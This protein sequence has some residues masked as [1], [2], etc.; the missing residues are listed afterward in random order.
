MEI[1]VALFEDNKNL[2][3]SLE[4]LINSSETMVCTGAFANAT[5]LFHD[6]QQAS[7]D[8]VMMDINM[9]GLSGIEAVKMI[10]EKFPNINILKAN[11]A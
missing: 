1:K 6:L 10:K 9:P 11:C 3:E 5:K 2:R 7:P 8:V 4:Q